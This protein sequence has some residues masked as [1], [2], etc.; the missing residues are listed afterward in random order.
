MSDTLNNITNM[1][2]G[3]VS[4]MILGFILL[5]AIF[6]ILYIIYLTKLDKSE[7]EFMNDLYSV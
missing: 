1:N 2:E 4:N 6:V 3:F 5:I 7:C